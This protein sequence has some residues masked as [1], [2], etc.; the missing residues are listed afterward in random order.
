MP[1]DLGHRS[2]TVVHLAVVLV[3]GMAGESK[4]QGRGLPAEQRIELSQPTAAKLAKVLPVDGQAA[5]T[6]TEEGQRLLVDL[7]PDS[8]AKSCGDL[9]EAWGPGRNEAILSAR[10]LHVHG[11]RDNFTV[12]VAYRCANRPNPHFDAVFDERPALLVKTGTGTALTLISPYRPEE[13]CDPHSVEF[14][15]TLPLADG[16]LLELGVQSSSYGDGADS[17]SLYELVWVADPAGHVALKID[18]RTEFNGYD[19]ESEV[20]SEQICEAKVRYEK[21]QAGKLS[22]IM[23]ETKCTEDKVEKPIQTVRYVWDAPNGVF[24]SDISPSRLRASAPN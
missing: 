7:L 23:A 9:V 21:D 1:N 24:R 20:S 19:A 12:L 10:L 16:E 22:A 3:L 15:K 13:C 5:A 18:S 14:L 2:L 11:D 17:S 8:S 4:A 6:L